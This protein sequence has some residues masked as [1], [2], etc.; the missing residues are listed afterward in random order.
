VG[1][2]GSS[3]SILAASSRSAN[4]AAAPR[5]ASSAAPRIASAT[6]GLREDT[7]AL[8]V[9]DLLIS[10]DFIGE[11]CYLLRRCCM[12]LCALMRADAR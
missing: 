1:R 12:R 3:E 5:C 6:V 11:K 9:D 8:Q 2:N 7:V 10:L 4:E